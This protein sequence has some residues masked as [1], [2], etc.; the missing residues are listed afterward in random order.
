MGILPNGGESLKRNT[1]WLLA[2]LMVL[3]FSAVRAEA[4]EG[5]V[6]YAMAVEDAGAPVGCMAVV[7][8]DTSFRIM[9]PMQSDAPETYFNKGLRI[10]LEAPVPEEGYAPDAVVTPLAMERIGLIDGEVIELGE[11]YVVSYVYQLAA[12]RED[13]PQVR[14]ALTED[15]RIIEEIAPGDFIEIFYDEATETAFEIWIT[16]G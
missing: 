10:T 2:V 3:S 6:Y 11:D 16:R 5:N 13:A 15:T 7:L 14:I 1:G 9:L 4:P 12:V 8:S